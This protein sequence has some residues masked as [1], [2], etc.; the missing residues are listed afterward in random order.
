MMVGHGTL[1]RLSGIGNDTQPEENEL[2][3]M[4]EMLDDHMEYC[5]GLSTGLEYTP[6]LYAGSEELE[7][8]ARIVGNHDR[9]I[10][11]HMR[12]EDD[13]QLEA[14]LQELISQGTYCKVHVAHIK[15]VYGKGSERAEE[16]LKILYD[17]RKRGVRITADMYPYTASYTGISILFPEW[18]KSREQLKQVLPARRS[19]LES[20]IRNKV[21]LRNGPEATLLGSEPYTG[22]TLADLEEE[23][24]LPFE[25]I[26]IDVIGPGGSSGAYFVMNEELQSRLLQDPLISVCSD[27]S[28]TGHH[29]RGHG[30]FAKIIEKYVMQEKA[31][32]LTEAIH[33][34]TAYASSILGLSDRGMIQSGKKADLIIF[35]REEVKAMADYPNPHQLSLGF[36][37]IIVN[38]KAVREKGKFSSALYGKVL[39]PK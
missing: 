6:G 33:K 39:Y 31:L 38:G 19:E 15:S 35:S 12:N 4:N 37:D 28:P 23:M 14:S 20:F 25:K 30:T 1:R 5:F 13:D 27:G 11:S 3:I 17:A 34:M 32:T 26:L 16:I 7:G 8:L 2:V 24:N 10:M 36:D 22:K 18:A 29:P 21:T 9:I